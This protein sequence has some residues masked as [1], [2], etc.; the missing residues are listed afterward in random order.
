VGWRLPLQKD[1]QWRRSDEALRVGMAPAGTFVAERVCPALRNV[2][3]RG[4]LKAQVVS[5]APEA[6]LPPSPDRSGPAAP[7]PPAQ[8]GSYEVNL[9][10]EGTV[11]RSKTRRCDLR[12][13][14]DLSAD[15]TTRVETVL[16]FLP[17]KA[18][19]TTGV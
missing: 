9:Q 6:S 8:A 1:L 10:P 17:R 2:S 4:T 11:L 13:G 3:P 19:L 12:L 7:P 16:G 18:R 15:I 5:I 14:M